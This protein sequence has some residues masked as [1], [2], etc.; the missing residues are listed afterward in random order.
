MTE[1]TK[2]LLDENAIPAAWY[3]IQADLPSPPP[4]VLHPGTLQPIGPDDPRAAVPDG[5]HR[6]GGVH[7]ARDRGP[8][9][10]ARGVPRMAPDP[11]LSRPPA[12]A[13]ARHSRAHLLQVRGREPHRQPQAEHRGR[14][15]VLQPAGGG[16]APRHGDRGRAVGLVARLRRRALRPG[17]QGV[18]G[19][20][21]LRPEAVPQGDD[22]DLRRDLRREPERGDQRGA[23]DPRRAPG[24]H[25]QP[26][27]RDQRGGGGRGDARG[28]QVLARKR[29]QPRA[30]APERDRSGGARAA[31][32]RRRLPRRGRGVH[33]RRQQLRGRRVPV[34]RREAARGPGRAGGGGGAGGVP[35]AHPGE[36][37]I[38][39]RRH[40]EDDA[41]GEDAHPGLGL[42]AL[43]LPRRGLAL[44]WHGAAGEPLRGARS[45]RA[46]CV[47]AGRMLRGRRRVRPGPRASSP[48]PRRPTP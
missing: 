38:R 1:P 4:P 11:A 28:H 32:A 27:H 42:R 45:G 30:H 19:A 3:N 34:H 16:L 9:A 7:R 33:R 41:A 26:R 24:Q 17:G 21:Q 44:P 2:Y 22:G 10:G 23:R 31:R 18:H 37:C 20:G 14:A 36:V 29:A 13:G 46:G 48:L 5:A 35:V 39:L 15:G 40:R 8:G 47:H 12:R 43:G 25:R 6:A